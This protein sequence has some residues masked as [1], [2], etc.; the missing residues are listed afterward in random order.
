MI[1]FFSLYLYK[2]NKMIWTWLEIFIIIICGLSWIISNIKLWIVIISSKR[3]NDLINY[4]AAVE[5]TF[6]VFM[7]GWLFWIVYLVSKI[8]KRYNG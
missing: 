1:Q 7:L 6:T 5:S 2:T 4:Q 8:L 3:K